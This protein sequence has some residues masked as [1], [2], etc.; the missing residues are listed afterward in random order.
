ME[1][2]FKLHMWVKTNNLYTQT[3]KRF[4][5]KARYHKM[6]MSIAGKI[7]GIHVHSDKVTITLDSYQHDINEIFLDEWV[8]NVTIDDSFRK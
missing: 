6:P 3:A 5:K 7:T 2:K 4:N 8:V 1:P